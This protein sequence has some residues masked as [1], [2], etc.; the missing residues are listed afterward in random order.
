MDMTR[1]EM[2][3]VINRGESVMVGDG[4]YRRIVSRIED[5]P[6]EVDAAKGDKEKLLA[7]RD[8]LL[9]RR[10]SLD[11][12]I[13]AAESLLSTAE[14]RAALQSPE[15]APEG[16]DQGAPEQTA[17][18]PA[19]SGSGGRSQITAAVGTANSDAE[20]DAQTAPPDGGPATGANTPPADDSGSGAKSTKK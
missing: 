17:A 4:P 5:L 7:A 16:G 9:A 2:I 11:A 3:A 19:E 15:H 8:G 18:G 14:N 6:S 12:E 1:D 20:S 10:A 13:A